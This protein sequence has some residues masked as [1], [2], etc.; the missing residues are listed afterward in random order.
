MTSPT[1]PAVRPKIIAEI[2]QGYEGRLDYC[3]FYVRA[4]ARAGADAIKFQIVYADDVA[5]P[6]YEYYDWYKQLEM[7]VEAWRA[8]RDRAAAE[9]IRFLANLSGDRAAAIAEAIGPDGITIHASNFFNRPL[10]KRAFD[11]G[12]QVFIYLGGIEI[13]EIERFCAEAAAWDV[14]DRLVLMYGFQAEPTPIEKSG[15]GN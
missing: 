2:A 3:D 11:T 12:A 9:G 13:D 15:V 5:E 14:L 10:I 8:V 1:N 4:A 7:P 6:G